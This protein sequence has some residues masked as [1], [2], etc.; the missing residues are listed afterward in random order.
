MF[1]KKKKKTN[2]KLDKLMVKKF[3]VVANFHDVIKSYRNRKS[4]SLPLFYLL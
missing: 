2:L 1:P 4:S 3:P